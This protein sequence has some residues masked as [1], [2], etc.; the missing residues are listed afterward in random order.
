MHIDTKQQGRAELFH[1]LHRQDQP[2]VLVNAWD[3]ASAR[4]IAKSSTAIA[5]SSAAVAA[6][7]GL[8]DGEQVPLDLVAEL[9]A[10][11]T[12]AVPVP[13][14]IDLEAGYGETPEA[15]AISASRM[16]AAGAVGINIEDGLIAGRRTLA[17]PELQ[18]RKIRAVRQSAQDFGV[19][20][21][22]NART[23]PFLLKFGSHEQCLE[24]AV[25]RAEIY[26]SAGADGIFVPGLSD[27]SLVAGLVRR[28]RLPINIMVMG[29]SP[30]IGDLARIGVRRVSMGPWP[31]MSMVRA[32]ESISAQVAATG[33]CGELF[34][35]SPGERPPS[36]SATSA[37]AAEMVRIASALAT[38]KS[39]QD[40]DKAMEIYHPNC[41]LEAP[42]FGSRREGSAQ[43][44]ESLVR[45]FA[46]FPDYSVNLSGSAVSGDTLVAWGEISAT[47]SGKP[48]G[49]TPNGRRAQVPVF[50][51]FRCSEGRIV[52]ESFNFDLASLCRQCG[53]T[54]DALSPARAQGADH[55]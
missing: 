21:F 42:P 2:L 43:I 27:L 3:V 32:I 11:L 51:L 5:T 37:K 16:L 35:S 12:A 29:S 22:I 39:R 36:E 41:V 28:V 49:Q 1:A 14:S 20:L 30:L 46:L 26:A 44:R 6:S 33:V 53:V 19:R 55:A 40:V 50:I 23:D 38:A 13:V 25:R 52:W 34:N 24:E 7:L 47:V 15:A 48:G 54:I 4:A 9:V 17:D 45:F 18:A 31:Q 10:R 8:A